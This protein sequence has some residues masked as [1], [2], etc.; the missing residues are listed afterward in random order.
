VGIERHQLLDQSTA[1]RGH[2]SQLVSIVRVR[3]RQNTGF[4]QQIAIKP[5]RSYHI[6]GVV[7]HLRQALA[8]TAQ[9]RQ[10][11]YDHLHSLAVAAAAFICF[12]CLFCLPHK[13]RPF[14]NQL[15]VI[16]GQP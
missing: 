5:Q 14:P 3:D 11:L 15:S 10:R 16:S 6:P 1:G 13:L 9:R 12:R 2:Q 7:S 8:L 4:I